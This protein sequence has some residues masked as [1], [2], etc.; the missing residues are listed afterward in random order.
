M[1][2]RFAADMDWVSR[3]LGRDGHGDRD[4]VRID[5]DKAAM[6]AF[7]SSSGR[8]G[9]MAAFPEADRPLSRYHRA[10]SFDC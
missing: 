10:D 9:A 1:R 4:H 2:V 5:L 3:H 8:S 6:A 7:A